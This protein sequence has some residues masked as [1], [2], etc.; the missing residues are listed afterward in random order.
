MCVC[1]CVRAGGA[2]S[3]GVRW[4]RTDR[5]ITIYIDMRT[6]YYNIYGQSVTTYIIVN[7]VL[8]TYLYTDILCSDVDTFF[9]CRSGDKRPVGPSKVVQ[10]FSA[11]TKTI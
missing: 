8:S 3:T 11:M 2:A 6:I 1:V 7:I 9:Q 4:H 5:G 10:H